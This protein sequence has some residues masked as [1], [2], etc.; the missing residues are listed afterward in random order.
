MKANAKT[1]ENLQTAVAMELAAVNQYMLHA[2]TTDDW[3][4]DKLAAKMRLEML[5]ELG[6]VEAYS[7][8]LFFMKGDPVL[9]PAKT[10]MRAHSLAEMFETDLADELAAIAFYT[11]AA[12]SADEAGDIGARNLF[13]ETALDEE[14][15]KAWL[16]Q[17]L[18]LL[19][20]M[21]EPAFIAMQ[22]SGTE[23][24]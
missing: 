17:Q 24:S 10:P 5:E 14:A 21:G 22:I 15:H 3:G 4:L 11:Q 20:R 23:S 19:A 7:K 16:E 9:K 8:R 18:S 2:L 13:E 1:L 12:R 6:H